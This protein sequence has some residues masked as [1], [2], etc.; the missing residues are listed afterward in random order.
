MYL[1]EIID[2]LARETGASAGRFQ[3]LARRLQDAGQMPKKTG[4][5]N[6][7]VVHIEDVVRLILAHLSG[8][9]YHEVAGAVARLV[10][11]RHDG[12]TVIDLLCDVMR[13][14]FSDKNQTG[15]EQ[16]EAMQFTMATSLS[17]VNS[18]DRPA[19][20]IRQSCIDGPEEFAFTPDGSA[21][22]PH[23][24]EHP[25]DAH[26]MPGLVIFRI[27][28]RLRQQIAGGVARQTFTVTA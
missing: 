24:S 18:P 23:L 27:G 3:M 13:T 7:P 2:V 17:V 15:F 20:V 22:K 26:T 16:I 12:M 5:S 1:S 28:R 10:A 9:E 6:R 8:R 14:A 11:Y 4:G 25:S 21:W 19:V